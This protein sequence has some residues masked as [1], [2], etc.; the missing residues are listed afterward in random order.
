MYVFSL[1]LV[2]SGT[3]VLYQIISR[4]V[5]DNH[6]GESLGFYLL[7]EPELSI[8]KATDKNI[9]VVK[10][11]EYNNRIS[12]LI[13]D[14][15]CKAFFAYRDPVQQ[16]VSSAKFFNFSLLPIR[17]QFLYH[18][19]YSF[20]KW[21]RVSNQMIFVSYSELESDSLVSTIE[22]IAQELNISVTAEYYQLLAVDLNVRS[23]KVRMEKAKEGIDKTNHLHSNHIQDP[24]QLAEMNDKLTEIDKEVIYFSNS[25]ITTLG[26]YCGSERKSLF[27]NF[28]QHLKLKILFY[29]TMQYAKHFIVPTKLVM[30]LSH[31]KS[32]FF[33][34]INK[35]I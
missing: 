33:R 3:T 28:P 24:I 12:T 18:M 32:W 10:F 26:Q 20:I 31:V 8:A 5:N 4:I 7:D 11:H 13:R 23:Q 9:Y 16:Y 6:K 27:G 34:N 1:G 2:R 17:I 35:Y 21:Q 22:K 25:E 29:S 19:K 15:N 30:L 14:Y